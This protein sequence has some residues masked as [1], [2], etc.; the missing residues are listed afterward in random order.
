MGPAAVVALLLLVTR[1]LLKEQALLGVTEEASAKPAPKKKRKKASEQGKP[2]KEADIPLDPVEVDI[3]PSMQY[4][5]NWH[6]ALG[7][8][9]RISKVVQSTAPTGCVVSIRNLL[10]EPPQPKRSWLVD[11]VE[12]MEKDGHWCLYLLG[13]YSE[14]TSAVPMHDGWLCREAFPDEAS[15][16][17][18][19]TIM[20]RLLNRLPMLVLQFNNHNGTL[21]GVIENAALAVVAADFD[22]ASKPLAKFRMGRDPYSHLIFNAATSHH[23]AQIDYYVRS[24]SSEG[25]TLGRS[26]FQLGMNPDTLD[27]SVPVPDMPE[28]FVIEF[29]NPGFPA[30]CSEGDKSKWTHAKKVVLY[31][32]WRLNG[33]VGP[34][35][36]IKALR[37]EIVRPFKSKNVRAT[38]TT[39][40]PYGG[41]S[42]LWAVEFAFGKIATFVRPA[43]APMKDVAGAVPATSLRGL[44]RTKLSWV[45]C[46]IQDKFLEGRR[47]LNARQ[48]GVVGADLINGGQITS[49]DI[50]A[51]YCLCADDERIQ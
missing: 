20:C 45:L 1:P 6:E 40:G 49:D 17:E 11:S 34:F 4:L 42:A 5:A 18:L 26:G 2:S 46:L 38:A 35:S 3:S 14:M 29:R 48:A 10:A 8:G 28:G 22:L 12:W 7:G 19:G 33:A 23:A 32:T 47:I 25:E 37:D 13:E 44:L 39:H 30:G 27:P 9:L 21:V 51:M 15:V 41:T 43:T 50:R 31:V 36:A 24:W 16:T